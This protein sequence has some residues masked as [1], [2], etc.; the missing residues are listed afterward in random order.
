MIDCK[1]CKDLSNNKFASWHCHPVLLEVDFL[2]SSWKKNKIVL[3]SLEM[4]FRSWICN[5]KSSM[6]K[7]IATNRTPP[8]S[9]V[10]G[11]QINHLVVL[12]ILTIDPHKST[13]I[14]SYLWYE[15]SKSY[16][17]PDEN[18]LSWPIRL[19]SM[20]IMQC[21]GWSCDAAKWLY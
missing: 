19:S 2:H 11:C 13:F 20:V 3:Q 4:N 10:Q 5:S 15:T 7:L 12:T 18:I 14:R 8:E 16:L 21:F 17:W 1:I 6:N 9:H